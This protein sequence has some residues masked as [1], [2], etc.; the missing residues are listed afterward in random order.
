MTRAQVLGL[1]LGVLALEVWCGPLAAE[2]NTD[3]VSEIDVSGDRMPR[4]APAEE[5]DPLGDEYDS[6]LDEDFGDEI[7]DGTEG[8]P[9]EPLNRGIFSFNEFLDQWLFDPV[10]DAYQF[11]F[12]EVF[13]T[14]VNNVFLNLQSPVIIVNHLLQFR[15]KDALGAAGSTLR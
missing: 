11:V 7:D 3:E 10:T 14:G 9:F 5:V 8:D 12:P 13:R 1:T 15:G 2:A 6:L 4:A